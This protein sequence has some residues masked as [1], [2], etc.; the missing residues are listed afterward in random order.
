[1]RRA[2]CRIAESSKATIKFNEATA[3]NIFIRSLFCG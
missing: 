3:K 1:M 2:I